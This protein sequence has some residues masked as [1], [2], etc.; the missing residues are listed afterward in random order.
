MNAT[1]ENVFEKAVL[2]SGEKNIN[3]AINQTC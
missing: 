1:K 2:S 3:K